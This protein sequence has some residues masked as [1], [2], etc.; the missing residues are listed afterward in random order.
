M[1]RPVR[2]TLRHQ[3]SLSLS[4]LPP[5]PKNG[6]PR[7]YTGHAVH[8][9]RPGADAL[10]TPICAA[11]GLAFGH[12]RSL[13]SL[14]LEGRLDVD[15]SKDLTRV[16]RGH[17]L[18]PSWPSRSGSGVPNQSSS[19]STGPPANARR[20]DPPRPARA[21]RSR[22]PGRPCSSFCSISRHPVRSCSPRANPAQSTLGRS[23]PDVC[24]SARLRILLVHIGS[25]FLPN[26]G[27]IGS[28]CRRMELN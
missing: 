25:L 28:S 27:D 9:G 5:R 17:R 22:S 20:V 1:G 26:A 4:G 23:V 13:A 15:W 6:W 12:K 16:L 3:R 24:Q 19:G 10:P 14:S 8:D 2:S 11:I 7:Q 21:A 18:Q